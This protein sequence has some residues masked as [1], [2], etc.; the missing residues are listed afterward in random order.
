L[1]GK[2]INFTF[3]PEGGVGFEKGDSEGTLLR[4]KELLTKGIRGKKVT[5]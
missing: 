4:E 5:L 3:P 1:H 2:N